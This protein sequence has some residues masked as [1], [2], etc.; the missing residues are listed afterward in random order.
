MFTQP[1]RASTISFT[2]TSSSDT[3]VPGTLTY[4]STNKTAAFTPNT[5]LGY[6]ATYTAKVSGAK[7]ASGSAMSAPISWSFTT[8]AAPGFAPTAS[9]GEY[10]QTD[11]NT[12]PNYGYD[13]TVVSVASG[14]WSSG[15]TWSTGKVPGAGA[16]VSIA[17][18]TTVT[19]DADSTAV[20][21]AI[22]IQP[23][24][25]LQ[26]ATTVNTE[27]IAANYLVLLGGTLDVGTQANPIAA[28]VT[29]TSETANQTINTTFD[30]RSMAIA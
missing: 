19:Y 29:A 18:G 23:S 25:T 22:T 16:V 30:P 11:L 5:I 24:G 20:L 21:S 4:N 9:V 12:I 8:A 1:V 26:F 28:N 27:V 17:S 2:L 14:S 13:P 10:I 3:S 6:A 15:S 7:N